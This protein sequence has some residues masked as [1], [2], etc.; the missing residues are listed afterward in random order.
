MSSEEK[1]LT[2]F[3]VWAQRK[4]MILLRVSLHPLE[5]SQ[6]MGQN[7]TPVLFLFLLTET[8]IQNHRVPYDLQM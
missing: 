1:V 3:V 4:D 2:P 7:C 6:H 8:G 5:V